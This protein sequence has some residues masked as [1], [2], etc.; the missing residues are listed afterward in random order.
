MKQEIIDLV[1]YRLDRVKNI[2][3]PKDYE[4]EEIP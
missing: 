2:Q 1:K 4:K 3:K